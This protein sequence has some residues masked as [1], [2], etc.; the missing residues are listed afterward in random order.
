MSW[1]EE[2]CDRIIDIDGVKSVKVEECASGGTRPLHQIIVDGG[3]SHD[4]MLSLNIETVLTYKRTGVF[5]DACSTSD[6][7]TG[8]RRPCKRR[9]HEGDV[10]FKVLYHV[11]DVVVS[12]SDHEQ[13]NDGNN[14][15]LTA[16]RGWG[17]T[18]WSG[19][20]KDEFTIDESYVNFQQAVFDVMR[21]DGIFKPDG[22]CMK[23]GGGAAFGCVI[24]DAPCSPPGRITVKAENGAVLADLVKSLEHCDIHLIETG[25]PLPN[26]DGLVF[27]EMNITAQV[28]KVSDIFPWLND[29]DYDVA[30]DGRGVVTVTTKA[31]KV[32]DPSEVTITIG[33][34]DVST[35]LT[36][37]W[38]TK[39]D[40]PKDDHYPHTC[41]ICKSPAY[42]GGD[43][44]IDCSSCSGK[45]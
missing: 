30:D 5:N 9:F 16:G 7:C 19:M 27:C 14:E 32:D 3:D 28:T 1:C 4:I 29:D 36:P 2:I 26:N 20:I 11:T 6:E 25:A 42:I 24:E 43:G 45:Y 37:P 39:D 22:D 31:S 12:L 17:K 10:G 8:W 40:A 18:N 44:S 21:L 41:T 33:G 23:P 34:G 15:A 13:P 35:T 38:Y